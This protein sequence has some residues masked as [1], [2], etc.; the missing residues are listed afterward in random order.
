MPPSLTI[1]DL[2]QLPNFFEDSGSSQGQQKRMKEKDSEVI[3]L[4]SK[5]AKGISK[6]KTFFNEFMSQ[7]ERNV[8]ENREF[9]S[10]GEEFSF[11]DKRVDSSEIRLE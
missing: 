7:V 6:I 8:E 4:K 2:K 9:Y 5:W 1:T 10:Y 3:V 11:R